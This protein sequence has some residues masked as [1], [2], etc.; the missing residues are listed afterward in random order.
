MAKRNKKPRKIID[1]QRVEPEVAK[2]F[3]RLREEGKTRKKFRAACEQ[4]E[5]IYTGTV[6]PYTGN[7]DETAQDNYNILWVNIEILLAA[8]YSRNPN[9]DVRRRYKDGIDRLRVKNSPP[10]FR[11]Q[12]IE[13]EEQRVELYNELGKKVSMTME[14]ALAYIQDTQDYIGS[15]QDTVKSYL[16]FGAGQ[17]RVRYKMYTSQGPSTKITILKDE[18]SGVMRLEDGTEIIDLETEIDI[19]EDGGFF[20]M[21]EGEE[22][23]EYE[24]LLNEWVP[25]PN[26]HWEPNPEWEDVNWVVI[27]HYL[28][29]EELI[30]QFGKELAAEIPLSFNEE[31]EYVENDNKKRNAQKPTQALIH[32]CFDKRERKVYIIAKDYPKMIKEMDDPYDLEGFYPFPKPMLGSMVDS[33]INPQADYHYYQD[34]HT[35]LNTITYRIGRLLEA[36]KYRGFYDGA[37]DKL[38]NLE[39]MQDGEFSAIP[40]FAQLAALV[41]SVKLDLR[42]HIATVPME[43]GIL[44]LERLYRWRQ[45]TLQVIHE[46]T[47]ISD[48]VRGATQASETL[49][50]QQIKAQ[51]SGLRLQTKTK[52][53]ER[54]FRDIK[55]I[56]AEFLSEKF[57]IDTLEAMTGMEINE[58]ME[59]ILSSDLLRSYVVD[60]ETDSTVV[61]DS[62]TEQRERSEAIAV[63]TGLF[64][65]LMPLLQI[66]VPRDLVGEIILFGLKGF[67]GARELEDKIQEM[68]DSE[69]AQEQRPGQQGPNPE[70]ALAAANAVSEIENRDA[71][72]AQ[73]R[74]ETALASQQTPNLQ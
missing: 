30:D 19:D 62:A 25:L 66:G 54:F 34:Q 63:M 31:G 16:K 61:M 17:M 22:V 36:L 23:I 52:E 68:L 60:I 37:I 71:D 72:T 13:Q 15:A 50:A 10:E 8:L 7:T 64:Q 47:G 28:N 26:F 39:V 21:E 44:L 24:E 5:K 3:E 51:Y 11:Q 58:E 27:D 69:P 29:E 53:V 73:K 9:P 48:I 38:I 18:D 43:E 49:G 41:D 40:D 6:S 2:W 45:E 33:G 65:Q 74:V 12:V 32:E 14:R 46:I 1:S 20:M 57:E 42:N 70:Q 4:I 35:E 67:K 55:R 56:E 59:E